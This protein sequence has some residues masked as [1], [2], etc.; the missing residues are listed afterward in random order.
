MGILPVVLE[1]LCPCSCG[2]HCFP[3]CSGQAQRSAPDRLELQ[4]RFFGGSSLLEVVV[5]SGSLGWRVSS[6]SLPQLL[7]HVLARDLLRL[8][9]LVIRVSVRSSSVV[10]E[11]SLHCLGVGGLS[12]VVSPPHRLCL[13]I[14][15]RRHC[16]CC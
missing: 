12:L 15:L 6:S 7:R 4:A 8:P 5:G 9:F 16:C 14:R 13:Q 10:L 11:A 2:L 3:V 1:R